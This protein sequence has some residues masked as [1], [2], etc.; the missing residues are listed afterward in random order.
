MERNCRYLVTY[1]RVTDDRFQFEI[2][3]EVGPATSAYAALGLSFD[4]KMGED[5]VMACTMAAA[6]HLDVAMYWNVASPNKN[7]LPLEDPHFGLTNVEASVWDG[8]L[9]CTFERE[10]VTR[11]PKPDNTSQVFDLGQAKFYLLL[12]SGGMTAGGV[13]AQ[14]TSTERSAEPQVY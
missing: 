11:V 10:A 12:A 5:S 1:A 8:F 9:Q 7:S 13:L 14:H 3:K 6:D 2:G 4:D